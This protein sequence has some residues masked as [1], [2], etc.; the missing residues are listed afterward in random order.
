MSK[1]FKLGFI[2]MALILVLFSGLTISGCGGSANQSG[3][4]EEKKGDQVPAKQQQVNINMGTTSATSSSYTYLAAVAK[5]VNSALP[6]VRI[7]PIESGAGLDNLKRM[8]QGEF[9]IGLNA[10]TLT[11]DAYAGQGKFDGKPYKELRIMWVFSQLPLNIAV[12]EDSGITDIAG[13]HGKE[14]SAGGTGSTTEA[15]AAGALK[16]LGVEPKYYAGSFD[17]AAG[18]ISDKQ[19]AG[20]V[21]NG[22]SNAADPLITQIEA[23]IKLRFLSFTQEQ[24]D[25]IKQ[26]RPN[27][28]FATMKAGTH[29]YQ[30]KD[31][32]NLAM[33][34][35]VLGTP[36]VSQD[37]GYQIVK[38]V[39]EGKKSQ[40][41]AFP[42]IKDVDYPKLTIDGAVIP[43]AAGTVQLLK[44]QG[45][46]VPKELI[47]PEYKEK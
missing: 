45:L 40:E 14:F 10:H 24:A 2:P 29:K 3:A 8:E 26:A 44:E 33:V 19:I 42:A 15:I 38:A 25:K 6:N 39:F 1:R 5:S 37:L 9:D 13:L 30:D 7:T 17:D 27:F 32:L 16:V 11:Y 21:K 23:S 43:L 41:S 34:A 20:I 4:K 22:P 36:K 35:M 46:D 28:K 47:P 18:A 31:T 12:R